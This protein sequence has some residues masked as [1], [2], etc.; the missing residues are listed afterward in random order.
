MKTFIF[1]LAA[2]A[3]SLT[4]R[5]VFPATEITGQECAIIL[6]APFL[7]TFDSKGYGLAVELC[8]E[9]DARPEG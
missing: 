6:D 2:F 1:L 7:S 9:K 4:L 5:A 3:L 8:A